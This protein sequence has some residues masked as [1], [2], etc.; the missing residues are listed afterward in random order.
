LCSH[1]LYDGQYLTAVGEGI[2]LAE[3]VSGNRRVVGLEELLGAGRR[4]IDEVSERVRTDPNRPAPRFAM[5]RL[6]VAAKFEADPY[7]DVPK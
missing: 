3:D 2:L 1:L 5:E 7:Q 6:N 4:E